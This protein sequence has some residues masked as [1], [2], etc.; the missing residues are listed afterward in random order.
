M[1]YVLYFFVYL[2]CV[3]MG[4]YW[5]HRKLHTVKFLYNHIHLMHHKYNKPEEV[6]VPVIPHWQ[7]LQLPPLG[8]SYA[9]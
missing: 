5:V 2:A 9:A 3:E 4:I 7:Y 1:A 6:R 8:Q